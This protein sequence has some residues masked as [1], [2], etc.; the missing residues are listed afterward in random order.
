MY[1]AAGWLDWLRLKI[2]FFAFL[3]TRR[4]A[5]PLSF[6]VALLSTAL[7]SLSLSLSA[8]YLFMCVVL[9]LT[10]F[11]SCCV[12][13]SCLRFRTHYTNWNVFIIIICLMEWRC[14]QW[15][16][17]HS[18]SLSHPPSLLCHCLSLSNNNNNNKIICIAIT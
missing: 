5:L 2:A 4:T 13:F 7:F 8:L 12:F 3:G 9:P 11:L 15:P 16:H 10:R 1:S 18:L 14:R 6:F 17:L